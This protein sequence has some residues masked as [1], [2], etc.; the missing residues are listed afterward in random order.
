[1]EYVKLGHTGL[2]VSRICLGCMSYGGS[3]RGNHAWSL[4]EEASRPFIK[5]ALESGINFFDT[6]NRYSLGSSEEILGRAIKDFA[7]REEVVIATK[8]Y[9][10]MRPGPNGAG[11]SRKAIM[12][13]IDASLQ[14]LGTDYV[15]LYQIHR[16]DYDTPIEETLEALHDVV[17]AGKVRYIGASS[18]HAWQFARALGI[19]ERHGWTRF[20]SMQNLVNL[21]YREEER[22]MLPLCAAEGIAVI[23]W[24]PQARGRLTRD[25]DYTSV[26]TETD[27]AFGRLFAK[28]EDADRKVVDRVAQI[29]A[30]RGISR[31]QVAL[32]WLLAKPV[33]TAPIV[34][35]TK[36]E[37]LDDALAS[38]NVKLSADEVAA[39]E[40][41]YVPHAVVGFV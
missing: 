10:R 24:S 3:N 39:L 27:E 8:V 35:A 11:L 29:A 21:L 17:K 9:G 26:R 20:V 28:T 12:A 36:L 31:A 5:R 4:D 18:M 6:A 30:A 32:A 41:P 33:I 2:D 23:P 15:D 13:E 7:R 37:H 34:G 22:E 25:W 16:W 40:E 1:V 14:R 38:V 19:A